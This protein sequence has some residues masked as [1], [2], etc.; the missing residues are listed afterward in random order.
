MLTF[1]LIRLISIVKIPQVCEHKR[2]SPSEHV[3]YIQPKKKKNQKRFTNKGK[4]LK[5]LHLLHPSKHL[6]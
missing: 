2:H 5:K 6:R 3:G 4:R 1:Q